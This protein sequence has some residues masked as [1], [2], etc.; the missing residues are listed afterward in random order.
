MG[1]EGQ[2]AGR[3]KLKKSGEQP[4]DLKRVTNERAT[5]SRVQPRL[6]ASVQRF[7]TPW[8]GLRLTLAL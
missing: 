1:L 4:R 5:V 2:K 3:D 6:N 7:R 8:N